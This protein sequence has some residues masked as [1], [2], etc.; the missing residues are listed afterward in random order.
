MTKVLA[1]SHRTDERDFFQQFSR[2]YGVELVL[3]KDAPSLE[4]VS[5]A[6]GISCISVITTPIDAALLDGLYGAGVRYISTRTVGYEHIDVEHARK[7]GMEIGNVSYSPHSVADYTVML[8]LMSLRHVK[9]VLQR[10]VGQDYSLR[11]VRGRELR[12]QTVGIIGTGRIGKAVIRNL[13]GF[14]CRI[15][16]YDRQTDGEIGKWADYV[17]LEE[18]YA[19]SDILSLHIPAG[20]DNSHLMDKA[21]IWKMKE[22]AVLINTARGSLVDTQALIDALEAGR[23]GGAALDVLEGETPIYY[24]DLKGQVLDNRALAVLSSFPNVIVTP[25]MAFYT[26]QAVSD[27]VE[28]SLLSC[29]LFEKGE[30]N[31]WA[32]GLK[33]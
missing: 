19:N 5:L 15:L 22:G 29:T 21:S 6:E 23:V 8:I 27:M 28:Y 10:S 13:S 33:K 1:Y 14:G 12:N 11:K 24:R 20:G 2:K 9:T 31:P 18:L 32:V 4:N 7:I 16:A 3:C 25:H 26:D 17:P 30:E